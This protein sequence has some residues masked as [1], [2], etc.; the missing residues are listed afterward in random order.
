MQD[1]PVTTI[2]P[3][4]RTPGD[5]AANVVHAHLREMILDGVLAPGTSINQVTLAADLGVSRTPVR[6]AIRMLQEEGLVEAEPQ[7]RARVVGFDPAHLDAVYTERILL[8]GLAASLTAPHAD[9]ALV[10]RLEESLGRLEADPEDRLS[11]AWRI[12]HA[13]FHVDLVSGVNPHL[14]RAIRANMDRG[15]HYRLNYRLMYET[16]GTLQWDTSP[17]EH[18]A[19]VEAY[20]D[21]DGPRAA[22]ELA[23]HLART[24][25]SLV[26][27]LAPTYDPVAVRSALRTMQRL[28]AAR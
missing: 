16:T 21:H 28:G 7:K 3:V 14:Q 17:A 2:Q 23:G 15:E 24:A 1:G 13:K 22:A 4:V 19:I 27:Q 10:A 8:E 6:E 9:D 5:H 12:E 20:L 11:P 18:H 25:L 26:A